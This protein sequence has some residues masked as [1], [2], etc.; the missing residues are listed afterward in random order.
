MFIRDPGWKRFGSGINIPDPQHVSTVSMVPS[1][2]LEAVKL[3]VKSGSG[4]VRKIP[5]TVF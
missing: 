5:E 4:V 3:I 2:Y 1:S